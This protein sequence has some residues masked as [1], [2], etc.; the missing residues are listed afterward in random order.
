[1]SPLDHRAGVLAL[2]STAG[3]GGAERIA[4]LAR[5]VAEHVTKDAAS[6]GGPRAA[7][8]FGY[9]LHPEDGDQAPALLTRA[10]APRIRML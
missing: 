2:V 6:D 7:L 4:R 10:A 9:A 1:M 8:A 5:A 3:A